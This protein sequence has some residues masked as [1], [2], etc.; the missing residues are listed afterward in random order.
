MRTIVQNVAPTLSI[1]GFMYLTFNAMV[2]VGV[3]NGGHADYIPYLNA[4]LKFLVQIAG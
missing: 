1:L 2:F 4:P 3:S